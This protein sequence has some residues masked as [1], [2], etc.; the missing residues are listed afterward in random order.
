MYQS[1]RDLVGAFFSSFSAMW[2]ICKAKM[3]AVLPLLT[4]LC[5]KAAAKLTLT[6]FPACESFCCALLHTPAISFVHP[7]TP[8]TQH[9]HTLSFSA[10]TLRTRP[11]KHKG[12][13][14]GVSRLEPRRKYRPHTAG[15]CGWL[16]SV[17]EDRRTR[18]TRNQTVHFFVKSTFLFPLRWWLNRDQTAVFGCWNEACGSM[19]QPYNL[20]PVEI[21]H[22]NLKI[23]VSKSD[24]CSSSVT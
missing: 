3:E 2:V 17:W 16:K 19:L 13:D 9:M 12:C 10:Q 8:K 22:L 7:N 14:G 5:C 1:Q 18:G 4:C 21:T 20:L 6:H 11:R 24:V 15:T 23:C